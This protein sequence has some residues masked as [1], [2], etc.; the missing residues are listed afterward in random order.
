MLLRRKGEG[1]WSWLVERPCDTCPQVALRPVL[2]R[3]MTKAF[4]HP[5]V[6]VQ[7]ALRPVLLRRM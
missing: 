1:A 4:R 5:C 3:P 7:A 6:P 2:L